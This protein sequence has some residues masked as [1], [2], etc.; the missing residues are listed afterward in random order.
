MM[1]PSQSNAIGLE[2][3]NDW[4][5][6]DPS[7][8]NAIGL[9]QWTFL[10]IECAWMC[11]SKNHLSIDPVSVFRRLAFSLDRLLRTMSL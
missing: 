2:H 6:M 7:Q 11:H 1:D 9:E 4:A 10:P 3:R 8:S 5:M